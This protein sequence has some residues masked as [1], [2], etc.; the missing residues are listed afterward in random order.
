MASSVA[1]RGQRETLAMELVDHLRPMHQRLA[2]LGR[3]KRIP[4]DLDQ[5]VAMALDLAAEM[6]DQH[7]RAEADAEE[8]PVLPERHVQPIGL[9]LDEL[10]AVVGAHRPAEHDRAGMAGQRFRQRVAERR[11]PDVELVAGFDAAAGRRGPGSTAP[12]AA[13]PGSLAGRSAPRR[14]YSLTPGPSAAPAMLALM[15]WRAA[16][17]SRLS[18][19][20]SSATRQTVL[21]S[22]SSRSPSA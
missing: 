5:P 8:G 16:M 13:P 2:L 17:R 7:L 19:P 11:P 1:P 10:V 6:V 20:I 14:R 12:D 15:R 9:A 18:T 22:S 4:A 3:R 21:S